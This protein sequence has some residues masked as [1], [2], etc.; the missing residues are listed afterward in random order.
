VALRGVVEKQSSERFPVAITYVERLPSGTALA[1]A[2]VTATQLDDS[3]D[4]SSTLLY[5]TTATVSG[6]DVV[7]G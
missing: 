7:V 4:A 1:S 6:T 2:T 5:S 3:S